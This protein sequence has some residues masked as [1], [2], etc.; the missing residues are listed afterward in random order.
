MAHIT[1]KIDV[2][3][4]IDL[5]VD[6]WFMYFIYVVLHLYSYFKQSFTLPWLGYLAPNEKLLDNYQHGG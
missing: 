6:K 3:H 5:L 4:N 1:N 2:L